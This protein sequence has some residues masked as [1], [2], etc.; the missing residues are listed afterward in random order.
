MK[1]LSINPYI[2][3]NRNQNYPKNNVNFGSMLVLEGDFRNFQ[4]LYPKSVSLGTKLLKTPFRRLPAVREFIQK[5]IYG[6]NPE[7]NTTRK[8]QDV[9]LHSYEIREFDVLLKAVEKE[10]GIIKGGKLSANPEASTRFSSHWNSDKEC[11]R[12]ACRNFIDYVKKLNSRADVIQKQ[13]IVEFLAQLEPVRTAFAE[14]LGS[15]AH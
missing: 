15:K 3:Q 9:F 5:E 7:R 11:D 1:I 10:L 2:S 8:T 4:L 14:K 12:P 13:T 6:I